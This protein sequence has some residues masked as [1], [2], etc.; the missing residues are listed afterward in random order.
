[1]LPSHTNFVA[2]AYPDTGQAEAIQRQLLTGG[3]VVQ[4]PQH[5]AVHHLLRITAHPQALEPATITALT[6]R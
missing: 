5:P 2:V 6:G 1:M 3:V 4:R